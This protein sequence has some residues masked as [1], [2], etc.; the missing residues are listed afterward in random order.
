MNDETINCNSIK[1]MK[2]C[3]YGCYLD[4]TTYTCDY[5]AKTG[6]LRNCPPSACDKY[7]PKE[8]PQYRSPFNTAIHKRK[9]MSHKKWNQ[10]EK[11]IQGE[12]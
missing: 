9:F 11:D 7:K 3:Q 1:I 2:S 4:S 6:R 8:A 12:R 5:F 10:I